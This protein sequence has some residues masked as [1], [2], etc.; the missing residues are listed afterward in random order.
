MSQ[1][2]VFV[3]K[4]MQATVQNKLHLHLNQLKA[5]VFLLTK[6]TTTQ[7]REWFH[8]RFSGEPVSAG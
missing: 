7:Y 4:V 3:D 1:F 8:G 6:K 5:R 2:Q